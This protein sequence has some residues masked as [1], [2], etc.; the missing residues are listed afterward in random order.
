MDLDND[1]NKDGIDY[2]Y[3]TGV[4]NLARNNCTMAIGHPNELRL[5]NGLMN[6]IQRKLTI[7]VCHANQN[8]AYRV[9][10]LD[11]YSCKDTRVL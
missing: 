3:I 11:S 8:N 4:I 5:V 6:T 10:G 1:K 7:Q 2:Y 9:K